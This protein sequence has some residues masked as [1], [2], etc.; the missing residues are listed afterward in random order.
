MTR[1]PRPFHPAN[2]R[3]DSSRVLLDLPTFQRA[4]RHSWS[5]KIAQRLLIKRFPLPRS[6]ADAYI[7][8]RSFLRE[9]RWYRTSRDVLAREFSLA[10]PQPR[11][12]A[13]VKRRVSM[14]MSYFSRK[15]ERDF[16]A[17]LLAVALKKI[18]RIRSEPPLRYPYLQRNICLAPRTRRIHVALRF[19]Y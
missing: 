19:R 14:Q 9:N 4:P 12:E 17:S 16:Y 7:Q 13:S 11:A 6:I 3:L 2:L 8:M 10:N 5:F 1:K 15:G 18:G